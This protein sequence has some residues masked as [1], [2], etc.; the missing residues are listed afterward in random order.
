M[1]SHSL[2]V[3]SALTAVAQIN[4]VFTEG[5]VGKTVKQMESDSCVIALQDLLDKCVKKV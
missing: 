1:Q 2:L 3:P 4:R 5:L